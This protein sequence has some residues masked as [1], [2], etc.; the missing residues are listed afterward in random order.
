MSRQLLDKDTKPDDFKRNP[1]I[2]G[3]KGATAAGADPDEIEGE[4][5]FE[6]DLENDTRADGS[7]NPDPGRTNR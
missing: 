5:T 3:S 4:N 6:G 1:G 2:G 7:L